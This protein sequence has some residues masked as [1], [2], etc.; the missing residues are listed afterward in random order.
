MPDNETLSEDL[1]PGKQADAG[2]SAAGD[3]TSQAPVSR[4][5]Y[6]KLSKSVL[7]LTKKIDQGLKA[8]RQS[9]TDTIKSVV[10]QAQK[11]S[12][13]YLIDRLAALLP[14]NG[15]SLES[16]KREAFL[17]E[18]VA[19]ASA[20]KDDSDSAQ[21][22][23]SPP[24]P[25]GPS[26]IQQEIAAILTE[27]GLTGEEP[28]LR[29]YVAAHKGTRWYEAGP[30]FADL[31]RKIAARKRGTPG[32]VMLGKVGRPSTSGLEAEYLSEVKEMRKQ[33]K[34]GLNLLRDLKDKYRAAGLENVDEI[35]LSVVR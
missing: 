28:E 21:E 12:N 14:A 25:T 6:E 13:D 9:A 4:A 7:D 32:G 24:A 16:I 10:S 15:P 11:S 30:G 22:V 18:Q 8:N 27:H 26:L 35:D 3:E 23:E 34:Y 33:R 29:E 5:E 17:D 31:A 19:K 2:A 20:G 1:L